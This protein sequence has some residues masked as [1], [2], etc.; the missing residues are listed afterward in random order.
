MAAQ[1]TIRADASSTVGTGHVMRMLALGQ[2]WAAQGGQVQFLGRIEAEPLRARIAAEGFGFAGLGA[3]HP[4]PSDLS[5]LLEHSAQGG[6][7]ALDGY[8]FDTGYQ[9]AVRAAGRNSLVMDDICDRRAYDADIYLNQN[10]GAE[11]LRPVLNSEA[12]RLIGPRYAL[13]R[14]EFLETRPADTP[15]PKRARNILVTFGGADPDNVSGLVLQALALLADPGMNVTVVVGA[16]NPHADAL[17]ALAATLP[18]RCTLLHAVSDMPG[19]MAWA[20]LAVSAAGSTCW[21][22]M[23]MGVPFACLVLADNQA[24]I[25]RRLQEVGSALSFGPAGELDARSLAALLEPLA[26]DAH[27]RAALV[28]CCAAQVDGR[29]ASRVVES[30]LSQCGAVQPAPLDRGL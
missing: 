29:G 20:D 15:H 24:G 27:A 11:T 6:W 4:D 3:V 7:V 14:R 21:E 18:G 13:L 12:L 2:E 1:L 19:L 30:M 9:C 22:L 5:T 16:A 25:A 10:M 17:R 28:R 23:F 26:A 8:H